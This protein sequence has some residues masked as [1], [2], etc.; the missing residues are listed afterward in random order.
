MAVVILGKDTYIE[1]LINGERKRLAIKDFSDAPEGGFVE[2]DQLGES[3]TQYDTR[4][5]GHGG[6]VGFVVKNGLHRDVADYLERVD[7][8]GVEKPQIAIQVKERYP[9]GSQ[10]KRRFVDVALMP[11]ASSIRGRK[12][13][14]EVSCQW[15]ASR[16]I[17]V[18]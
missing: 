8:A 11:P 12:D 4:V 14:V 2:T 7:L 9:D 10:R 6:N 17:P 16:C 13:P 15:K 3:R 1:I 18:K 5:D